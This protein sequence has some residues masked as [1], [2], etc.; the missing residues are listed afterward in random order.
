MFSNM[1]AICT[2]EASKASCFSG[3]VGENGIWTKSQRTYA[4]RECPLIKA[5]VVFKPASQGRD[6]AEDMNDKI[7]SISAPYLAWARLD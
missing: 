5:D 6:G 1:W 4:Y 3:F 7:V 2:P